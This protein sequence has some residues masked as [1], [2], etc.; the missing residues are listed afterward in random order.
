[1]VDLPTTEIIEPFKIIRHILSIMLNAHYEK[2]YTP[3]D[4]KTD[5][6]KIEFF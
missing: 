4:F 5:V 1:M 2:G 3:E 6:F